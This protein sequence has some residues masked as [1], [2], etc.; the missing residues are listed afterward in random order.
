L[1]WVDSATIDNS[2]RFKKFEDDTHFRRSFLV[3]DVNIMKGNVLRKER[4]QKLKENV[5]KAHGLIELHDKLLWSV[6][7]EQALYPKLQ[8]LKTAMPKGKTIKVDIF[9][10]INAHSTQ[11]VIGY[12][13]GSVYPDSFIV[14]TAHYDHLGKMGKDVYFPGANDN[15]SGTAMLLDLSRHFASCN[16]KS[17]YSVVFIAFAGEEAGLLGS[18]YYTQHPLFPLNQIKLLMNLD[19]MG[20]GSKGATVVNATEFPQQY[21]L[22]EIVNAEKDYLPALYQR[23][24]AQNSDHYFFSEMGVPAFF[25]Y[26][27]GEY[28]YYHE[29][30]DK[31]E[32]LKLEKYENTF[33]LMCDLVKELER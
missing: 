23:G 28:P 9:S 29:P 27:M 10:Q 13:R 3:L 30:E 20:T 22:I 15:A 5:Y 16:P 2:G 18:Y 7:T 12:V 33:L 17:K 21:N 26:L 25:M 32:N 1:V 24:K 8:V 31:A 11:N 4:L 19:L 14:F 6:S